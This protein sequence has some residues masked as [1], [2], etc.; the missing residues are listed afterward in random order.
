[1]SGVPPGDPER[2]AA[3][4]LDE[5]RDCRR[6]RGLHDRHLLERDA[7]QLEH[8]P[9]PTSAATDDKGAI[10]A[11]TWVEY[12]VT[13]FVTGNGTYSFRLATMLDRRRVLLAARGVNLLDLNWWP[14]R[15]LQ[16]LT[17]LS[18]RLPATA[19]DFRRRWHDLSSSVSPK[20]IRISAAGAGLVV[21]AIA[22]AATSSGGSDPKPRPRPLPRLRPGRGRQWARRALGDL[23]AARARPAGE[24]DHRLLRRGCA[25]NPIGH[26]TGTS[27]SAPSDCDECYPHLFYADGRGINIVLIQTALQRLFYPTWAPDGGRLAAVVLGRGIHVISIRDRKRAG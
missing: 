12:D 4:P 1:M 3:P 27:S 18:R 10:P 8:P 16:A 2:Q 14:S 6:P 11:N 21:I 15:S 22:I 13:P 9:A 20:R 25:T 23:R 19:P 5:R 17:V 24:A 7:D 26:R